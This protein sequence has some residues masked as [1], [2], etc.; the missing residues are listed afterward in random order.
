M[1]PFFDTTNFINNIY[2]LNISI[3]NYFGNILFDDDLSRII[4]ASNEFCFRKRVSENNVDVAN[5]N[6]PFMNYYLT[7]IS[8]NTDRRWLSNTMNVQGLYI[9]E[10]QKKIRIVPVQIQYEMTLFIQRFDDT[11]NVFS[12]FLKD[13]SNETV[14]FP[15]VTVDEQDLTFSAVMSYNFSFNTVYNESDWL[16]INNIYAIGLDINFNSQ[17]MYSNEEGFGISDTVC[18]NYLTY[19]YG[20]DFDTDDPYQTMTEEF[21]IDNLPLGI[22]L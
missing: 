22:T 19:K 11:I 16:K 6:L 1:P 9:E 15:Q 5:L 20:D 7:D 13:N 21:D 10:I 4:Y 18:L 3:E 12:K 17:F 2:A 8:L 14:L